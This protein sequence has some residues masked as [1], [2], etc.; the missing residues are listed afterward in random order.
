LYLA[1]TQA[2][3]HDRQNVTQ[4]LRAASPAA[5]NAIELFVQRR[6]LGAVFA[7]GDL[8]DGRL[9]VAQRIRRVG[10]VF[11]LEGHQLGQDIVPLLQTR[12]TKDLPAGDDLVGDAAEAQ[13][14]FHVRVSRVL[15]LLAPLLGQD[16]EVV[17]ALD[18]VVGDTEDRGAQRAIAALDQRAIRPIDFVALIA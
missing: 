15:L 6:R 1:D 2:G 8:R 14:D 5:L 9:Q 13:A 16:V 12:V 11:A 3:Q 4:Q 18:E 7:L 17:V 10:F